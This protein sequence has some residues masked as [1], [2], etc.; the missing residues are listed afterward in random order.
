MLAVGCCTEHERCC[1]DACDYD[2]PCDAW[3]VNR[4]RTPRE[5]APRPAPL[6]MAIVVRDRVSV[7]RYL[8]ELLGDRILRIARWTEAGDHRALAALVVMAPLF[9]VWCALNGVHPFKRKG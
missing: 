9:I 6:P 8:A 7:R 5:H 1:T 2:A 4:S 3:Y